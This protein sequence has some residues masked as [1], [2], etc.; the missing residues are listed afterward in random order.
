[1]VKITVFQLRSSHNNLDYSWLQNAQSEWTRP[2]GI[3][4]KL[5]SDISEMLSGT[6]TINLWLKKL[7]TLS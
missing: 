6:L 2:L 7:E 3:Q 4:A 5:M 1:M